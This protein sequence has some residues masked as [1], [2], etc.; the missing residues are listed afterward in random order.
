MDGAQRTWVWSLGLFI[1]LLMLIS[2]YIFIEAVAD[3]GKC[4]SFTEMMVDKKFCSTV[5]DVWPERYD[6]HGKDIIR[7]YV[8]CNQMDEYLAR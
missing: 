3:D 1:A 5:I 7:V 6:G 8:P 2:T 4:L